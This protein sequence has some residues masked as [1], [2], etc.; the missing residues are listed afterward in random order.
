MAKL[1]D[2]KVLSFDCYGTLIDWERG[3]VHALRPLADRSSHKVSDEDLLA[4]HA[5]SETEIQQNNPEAPYPQVLAMECARVAAGW[6]VNVTNDE[7]RSFGASVGAWPAFSD[8]RE[9]LAYLKQHHKLVILSNIDKASFRASNAH[10]GVEFD[11]VLT[12]EEIGSYKPDPRNFECLI[13]LVESWGLGKADILHTAESLYHDH[14]PANRAG[15]ASC[16]IH[17][18]HDKDGFGA[19]REPEVMPTY[20]FRFTSMEEM[21]DAHRQESLA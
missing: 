19:T 7:C 14:A 1:Q 8:S 2:F 20:D 11:A 12:A 18:R 6:G 5:A 10:L 3:I 15:L 16:W 9:T 13:K 21:A 4:A 17:R